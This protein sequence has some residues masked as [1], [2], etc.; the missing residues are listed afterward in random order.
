VERFRSFIVVSLIIG[1]DIA[2]TAVEKNPATEIATSVDLT[3]SRIAG[4][5]KSLV[6]KRPLVTIAIVAGV[7]VLLSFLWRRQAHGR[8]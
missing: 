2:M 6:T 4:R 3:L 1:K 5:M 8:T 7:G